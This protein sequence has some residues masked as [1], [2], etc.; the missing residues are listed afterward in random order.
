M[1]RHHR[2]STT[3]VKKEG[4]V[5]QGVPPSSTVS[6]TFLQ[7]LD[8]DL[9][10]SVLFTFAQVCF[11]TCVYKYGSRKYYQLSPLCREVVNCLSICFISY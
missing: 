6:V 11:R 8:G 7:R 3:E 10:I 9:Y 5:E 2:R 1:T 4:I